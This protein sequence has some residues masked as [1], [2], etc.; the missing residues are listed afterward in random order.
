[1]AQMTQVSSCRYTLHTRCVLF[2][3]RMTTCHY[4]CTND[5]NANLCHH[6]CM[7]TS[8]RQGDDEPQ[9]ERDNEPQTGRQRA[10]DRATT[11]HRQGDNEPQTE[12][13]NMPQTERDNMLQTERDNM[14]QTERDNDDLGRQL[15]HRQMTTMFLGSQSC[16]GQYG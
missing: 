2:N 11:S 9:T 3:A 10:T 16:D 5:A 8:H 6:Q 7:T 13:D 15:V 4:Q 12:R 14:P 1:M